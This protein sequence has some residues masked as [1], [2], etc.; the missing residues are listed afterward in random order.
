MTFLVTNFKQIAVMDGYGQIVLKLMSH[1]LID[2][3]STLVQV[4]V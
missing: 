2:G 4:M 3:K 1:D